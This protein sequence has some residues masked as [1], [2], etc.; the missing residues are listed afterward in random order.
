MVRGYNAPVAADEVVEEFTLAGVHVVWLD[1]G[2]Q[3][4]V[5]FTRDGERL[6]ELGPFDQPAARTTFETIHTA[7][8]A[9]ALAQVRRL[10]S[11][12]AWPHDD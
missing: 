3:R 6:A 8:H 2:G 7:L 5:L 1:A 4:I 11:S 9:A 10:S 12:G